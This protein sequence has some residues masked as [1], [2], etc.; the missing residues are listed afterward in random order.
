MVKFIQKLGLIQ[1][2]CETFNNILNILK[3]RAKSPETKII[4][5]VYGPIKEKD[6]R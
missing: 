6:N 4:G 5:K 3:K 2:T 1:I